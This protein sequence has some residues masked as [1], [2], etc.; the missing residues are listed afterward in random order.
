MPQ[1]RHRA[2][3]GDS[4]VVE[5]GRDDDMNYEPEDDDLPRARTVRRQTRASNR[6]PEPEFVMPPLDV[7]TLEASWAEN[8]SRSTRFRRRANGD[9]LEVRRNSRQNE[10]PEKGYRIKAAKPSSSVSSAT[11][12]KSSTKGTLQS[13]TSQDFFDAAIEH[14]GIMLS[15][16]L[17]VLGGALRILKTPISII[18]AIYLLLGAGTLLQTLLTKSLYASLSP[19]CRIPGT[20]LLSLPFCPPPGTTVG[21]SRPGAAEFDQLMTVQSKFD[22]VLEKSAD[23][24]SL[25]MDMKRGEASIR[26]LR[27]LVRYS[28]LQAK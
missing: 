20:A 3:L 19:V 4:W 24:V 16:T 21:Q 1:G 17:E 25:P 5:G 23:G 14:T 11:Y 6:S 13:A 2:Q 22:E 7:D 9:G 28:Q 8:S 27:Q 15:Y 26:D 18:L 12:A 10:M